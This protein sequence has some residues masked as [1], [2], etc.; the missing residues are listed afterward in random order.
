QDGGV[1]H[2]PVLGC[3]HDCPGGCG[4]PVAR[5]HYACRSCWY[6]LPAPLRRAITSSYGRE[7]GAHGAAI[8]RA[9]RWYRDDTPH[10]QT[11]SATAT[12]RADRWET[13]R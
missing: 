1:D 3:T 5:H 10:Q 13:S 7:P 9:N 4:R 6:R 11:A 2:R 12:G 8:R